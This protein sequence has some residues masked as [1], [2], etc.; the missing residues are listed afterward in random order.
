MDNEFQKGF[1]NKKSESAQDE[2]ISE[3]RRRIAK[4]N[5]EVSEQGCRRRNPKSTGFRRRHKVR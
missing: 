2:F 1:S 3:M 4:L 5:K